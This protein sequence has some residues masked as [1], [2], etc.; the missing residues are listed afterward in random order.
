MTTFAD[1]VGQVKQQLLG[2]TKDQV[3]TTY[4]T[5]P[6]TSTDTTFTVDT[7]TVTAITRGLIEVDEELVLIKKF[8]RTS[9]VV[10]VMAGQTGRGRDG[11]LATSHAANVLVTADPDFPIVRIKEA[12]NSC[13]AATYPDLFAFSSFEFKKNAA[14]YEYLVPPDADSVYKVTA[15]TIGPSKIWFPVQRWRFNNNASMDPGEGSASGKTIQVMDDIVPGRLIRVVYTKAPN[16]LVDNAD[17]FTV[18][19][20]PERY[21]DMIMYGTV[22]RLLPAYEAARLQQ[23]SIESAER[24]PLVPTQAATQA[25]QYYWNMYYKRLNEERDRLFELNQQ[26]QSFLS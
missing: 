26:Y 16:P 18:T 8:D 22:A 25:S 2:Y 5:Q 9:G 24:A 11:T 3:A 14:R 19:G 23:S 13:I 20:Y 7:E 6:M 17:E 4:L 10:T 15:D 1:L 21:T 12:V